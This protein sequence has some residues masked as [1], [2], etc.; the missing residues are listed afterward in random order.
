[1]NGGQNG[2]A[3]AELTPE[4]ASLV[5]LL[6][7]CFAHFWICRAL[8]SEIAL[9]VDPINLVYG[10]REFNLAHHAPHPPGY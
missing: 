9:D 7:A 3:G 2:K 8:T 5:V 1:M 4:R 6:V 10:M